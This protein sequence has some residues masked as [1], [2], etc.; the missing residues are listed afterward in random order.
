VPGAY[1][2]ESEKK[3]G[4]DFLMGLSRTQGHYSSQL[5]GPGGQKL[6]FVEPSKT[7][8][9]SK[10]VRLLKMNVYYCFME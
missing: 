10:G 8:F 2:E 9:D 4:F 7:V 3:S 1:W 5:I 6:R